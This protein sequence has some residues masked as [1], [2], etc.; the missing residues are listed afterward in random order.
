MKY[1]PW[2]PERIDTRFLLLTR[3]NPNCYEVVNSTNVSTSSFNTSRKTC[4]IIHGYL[5]D[6]YE[7]WIMDLCKTLL[8]VSDLNC[9]SVDWGCGAHAM[10]MQ[11]ANNIRVVGAEVANF[12]T[13]LIDSLGYHLSNVYLIGHSLGA[14]AA[15]EAGKR[16]PGIPRISGMDPAG[17]YFRDTPPEVRLDPTDADFVDAIHTDGSGFYSHLGLGGY[18]MLE[19]SGHLDFYPNGGEHMPGCSKMHIKHYDLGGIFT[20]IENKVTCNHG[21][22]HQFF[23]RS[24]VRPHG[25]ISYRGSSYMAFQS[26]SGDITLGNSHISTLY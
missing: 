8:N 25:F 3:E 24:I 5:D 19:P 20:G 1:L 18:G 2:P 6:G 21:R 12:L 17:P 16:L 11:A 4:M 22:S 26:V 23:T 14:H 13:E 10:Y 7:S 15:G 9:F